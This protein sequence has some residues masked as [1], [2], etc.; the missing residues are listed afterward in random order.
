MPLRVDRSLFDRIVDLHV[1]ISTSCRSFRVAR[2]LPHADQAVER[3]RLGAF[4]Q[5]VERLNGLQFA[6]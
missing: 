1:M 5:T 4:N 6:H 2:R 3:R